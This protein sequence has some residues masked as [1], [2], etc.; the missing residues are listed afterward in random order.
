MADRRFGESPANTIPVE[1]SMGGGR[2]MDGG[3]LQRL[4]AAFGE[5]RARDVLTALTSGLQGASNA[6]AE[7]LTLPVD[8]MSWLLR[9][10]GVDVGSSPIGGEDWARRVGLIRDPENKLA[11]AIGEGLGYIGTSLASPSQAAKFWGLYGKI[12]GPLKK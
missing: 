11:G 10:H 9:Q 5:A 3:T 4:L 12:P 1:S 2:E 8:A 6:S 7:A